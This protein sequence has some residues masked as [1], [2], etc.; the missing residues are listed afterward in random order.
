MLQFHEI[1][2]V[3]KQQTPYSIHGIFP[4]FIEQK[5]KKDAFWVKNQKLFGR[6]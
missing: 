4:N 5:T 6:D 3:F 2:Y 1:F